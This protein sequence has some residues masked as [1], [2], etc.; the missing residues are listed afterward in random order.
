MDYEFLK[1]EKKRIAHLKNIDE[2][3]TALKSL[4]VHKDLE[5]KYISAQEQLIEFEGSLEET[6]SDLTSCLELC[7]SQGF[8][9]PRIV[10][11]YDER[12]DERYEEYYLHV[13]RFETD[14]EY[15]KRLKDKAKRTIEV[16][17]DKVTSLAK[18]QDEYLNLQKKM[19]KLKKELEKNNITIGEEK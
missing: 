9:N 1:E 2:I 17:I 14:G 18:T 7:N 3:I 15:I 19:D 12:Y 8:K 5:R 10:K 6:I 13:S 16:K 4:G 11:E